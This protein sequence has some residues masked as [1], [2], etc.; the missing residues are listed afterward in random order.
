LPSLG[1]RG[2]GWFVLQL[3][4]IAGLLAAGLFAG[5]LRGPLSWVP[6]AIGVALLLAGGVLFALGVRELGVALT[7]WPRPRAGATIVDTGVYRLVRHPIYGGLVLGAFGWAMVTASPPAVGL[8]VLLL[9]FLD[10][11]ARREEAWLVTH[12]PAYEDYRRRTRKMVPWVF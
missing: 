1:P 3:V 2:E 11:K 4:L 5:G 12:D 6:L 8:A 7:P 9:F 10:L